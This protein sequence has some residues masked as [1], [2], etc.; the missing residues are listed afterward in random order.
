MSTICD[1]GTV[2][3]QIGS[4]VRR[5]LRFGATHPRPEARRPHGDDSGSIWSET[6]PSTGKHVLRDA[7]RPD[8][9]AERTGCGAVRP[10]RLLARLASGAG[11]ARHCGIRSLPSVHGEVRSGCDRTVRRQTDCAGDR[12]GLARGCGEAGAMVAS[13][14]Q[15]VFLHAERLFHATALA[16]SKRGRGTAV[17]RIARDTPAR[18]ASGG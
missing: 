15:G 11:R 10:R 2:S 14:V 16:D 18:W 3:D 5:W 9:S 13:G 12:D 7:A 8:R 1:T 4:P 6:A 17:H